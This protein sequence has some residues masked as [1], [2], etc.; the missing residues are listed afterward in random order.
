MIA[1]IRASKL[2]R[3]GVWLGA[4]IVAGA[5]FLPQRPGRLGR[6]LDG[7]QY[8]SPGETLLHRLPPSPG[9]PSARMPLASVLAAIVFHHRPM[10]PDLWVLLCLLAIGC[11]VAAAGGLLGGAS[12]AAAAVLTWAVIGSPVLGDYMELLYTVFVLGAAAALVLRARAPSLPRSFAAAAALGATFLCRSP[13]ALFPPLLLVFERIFDGPSRRCRKDALVM[14]FV[15]YSA[16]LPWIWMNWILDRKFLPFEKIAANDNLVAAALGAVGTFEG[17]SR[18]LLPAAVRFEDSGAV[19]RWAV[20]EIARHPGR[21]CAGL[22]ERI[23]FFVVLHPA[24]LALALFAAWRGRR[25]PA[26]RAVALLAAYLTAVYLPF[27]V[28]RNYFFPVWSLAALLVGSCGGL[29]LRD[30]PGRPGAVSPIAVAAAQGWAW[31]AAASWAFVAVVCMRYGMAS[32]RGFPP[33]REALEIA[34]ERSPEPFLL[35]ERGKE[36]IHAGDVKGAE[37]DFRRASGGGPP[38]APAWFWLQW[39]LNLEGRPNALF[40]PAPAPAIENDERGARRVEIE[41][42]RAHALLRGA[43]PVEAEEHLRLALEDYDRHSAAVRGPETTAARSLLDKLRSDRR[44]FVEKAV[45]FA[46]ERPYEDKLAVFS[47]LQAVVPAE[48]CS[49]DAEIGLLRAV[50]GDLVELAKIQDWPRALSLSGRLVQVMPDEPA[51]WLWR[52]DLAYRSGRPDLSRRC[53]RRGSALLR[54]RARDWLTQRAALL[55]RAPDRISEDPE[56]GFLGAEIPALDGA[57]KDR[58]WAKGLTLSGRLIEIMPAEPAPWFWRAEFALLSGRGALARGCLAQ[59]GRCLRGISR[60]R[61]QEVAD[62]LGVPADRLSGDPQDLYIDRVE[63]DLDPLIKQE[64][65]PR[66]LALAGRLAAFLPR[67]AEPWLRLAQVQRRAGDRAGALASLARMTRAAPPEMEAQALLYSELSENGK[68][69]ETLRSLVGLAPAQTRYRID[70]GVALFAQRRLD[71]AA[72]QFRA[73]ALLAPENLEAWSSLAAVYQAQGK[74]DGAA[75]INA[76]VRIGPCA[77]VPR[78]ALC[79]LFEN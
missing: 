29:I 74:R 65:W 25:D 33:A 43:R 35:F 64:D 68:A 72:S 20:G 34:A 2:G 23:L 17:D 37:E 63:R 50:K 3:R 28:Q 38:R 48:C 57:R 14:G 62:Q 11:L 67:S 31:A 19:W 22:G 46:P 47:A 61:R 18:A 55:G 16:L 5:L 26:I 4:I 41:L 10:R 9:D 71:E 49:F 30:R 70:F 53:L 51:P 27:A 32:E 77:R 66:S 78:D 59:F 45:G 15:P 8:A 42:M 54:G 39:A 76:R 44:M 6:G 75:E 69:A 73:A 7:E 58:D 1:N 12:V 60:D 13:L 36:R 56:I 52:A 40:A 24:A 79:G 21:Y